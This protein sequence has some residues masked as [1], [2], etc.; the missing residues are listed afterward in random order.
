MAAASN[1][2]EYFEI[3]IETGRESFARP[4][5]AETVEEDEVELLWAAL[6]RL[7]SNKRSNFAILRRDGDVEAGGAKAE[8]FDVRKLTRSRRE[9][10]VKK[11]FATNEQDNFKL[12]LAIKE[13]LDRLVSAFTSNFKISLK[14]LNII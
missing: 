8:T 11:A 12:L 10:V 13:R 1:G 4:S 7:P 6:G 3:E 5:N 9:L 14:L 2:S